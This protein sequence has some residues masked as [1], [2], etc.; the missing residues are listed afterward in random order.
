MP[1]GRVGRQS[2]YGGTAPVHLTRGNRNPFCQ[3]AILALG[4]FPWS[5]ACEFHLF[6]HAMIVEDF[7]CQAPGRTGG[8][9]KAQCRPD[10]PR[11]RGIGPWRPE[12]EGRDRKE[13]RRRLRRGAQI[14]SW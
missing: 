13:G 8:G 10:P 11:Y 1:N 9:A 12:A 4:R 6:N 2:R 3:V 7:R 5:S 14:F